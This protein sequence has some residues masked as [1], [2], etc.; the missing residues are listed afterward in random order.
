MK[1][2]VVEMGGSIKGLN[3]VFNSTAELMR[4]C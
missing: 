3:T 4:L 2:V 1:N